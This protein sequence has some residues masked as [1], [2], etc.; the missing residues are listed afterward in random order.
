MAAAALWLAALLTTACDSGVA[1]TAF[2]TLPEAGW[3]SEDTLVFGPAD[4]LAEGGTFAVVVSLRLPESHRYPYRE[5]LLAVV[6]HLPDTVRTDTLSFNLTEEHADLKGHGM[7][8]RQYDFA[9]DTI[10]LE[11]GATPAFDIAHCMRLSPLPGIRDVGV[12]LRRTGHDG[13]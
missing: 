8:L 3:D 13:W 10:R 9:I 2:R 5:L 1:T 12:T 11:A 4:T 7:S 6:S